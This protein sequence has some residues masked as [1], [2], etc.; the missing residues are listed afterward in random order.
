VAT[1]PNERCSTD[2]C[3]LWTE[4]DG[5]ATLALVIDCNTRELLGCHLSRSGKACTASS[6]LEH[7]LIACFGTPG[8]VPAPFLLRSDKQVGLHVWQLQRIDT[9]LRTTPGVHHA[10]LP[11]TKWDVRTSDPHA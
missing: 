5:W 2:L 3:R 10:V 4:R 9:K 1:R 6:A 7:V 8:R 11:A